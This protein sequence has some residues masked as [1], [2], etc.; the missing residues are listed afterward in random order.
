MRSGTLVVEQIVLAAIAVGLFFIARDRTA[1]TPCARRVLP[2]VVPGIQRRREGF[3]IWMAAVAFLVLAAWP[4]WV[5]RLSAVSEHLGRQVVPYHAP[6]W[7]R[8][9]IYNDPRVTAKWN[10]D[11]FDC[12]P[13]AQNARRVES[14]P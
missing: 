10:P 5:A 12:G 11:A 7:N 14:R 2:L 6:I 1:I 13:G 3:C 9:A 8:P 4:P